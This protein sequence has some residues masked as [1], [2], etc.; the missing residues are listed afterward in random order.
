MDCFGQLRNPFIPLDV[1]DPTLYQVNS[2]TWNKQLYSLFYQEYQRNLTGEGR[3][4][5]TT[6]VKAGGKAFEK[7]WKF[8]KWL[9]KEDYEAIENFYELLCKDISSQRAR[10]GGDWVVAGV[11]IQKHQRD[12]I[13]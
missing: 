5:R 8:W 7:I 4:E 6:V 9:K 10:I 1:E 13:R 12:I 2:F 11:V 3:E